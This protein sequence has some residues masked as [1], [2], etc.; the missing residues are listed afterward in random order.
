MNFTLDKKARL[1]IFGKF[2]MVKKKGQ[3]KLSFFD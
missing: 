2:F 3:L 1:R